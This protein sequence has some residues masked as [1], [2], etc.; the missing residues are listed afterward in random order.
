MTNQSSVVP[1]FLK[2]SATGL[3]LVSTLALSSCDPL[4]GGSVF[5]DCI[6]DDG[7][8]LNP[9]ELPLPVLNHSYEAV[10]VASIENEPHDDRFEYNF[11]IGAGLPAGLIIDTFERDIRISGAPTELGNYAVRIEVSVSDAGSNGNSHRLC[12]RK[13]ARN[14]IFDVQQGL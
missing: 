3:L 6:D 11:N 13:T 9:R 2:N 12:R 8:V 1:G 4:S 5:L 10:I 7:P 14:Y